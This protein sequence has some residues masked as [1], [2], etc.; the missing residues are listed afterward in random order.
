M[1]VYD[2]NVCVY[3]NIHTCIE[4]NAAEI[5]GEIIKVCRQLTKL[6]IHIHHSHLTPS[7]TPKP[8]TSPTSTQCLPAPCTSTYKTIYSPFLIYWVSP[9]NSADFSPSKIQGDRKRCF[10]PICIKNFERILLNKLQRNYF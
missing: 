7:T 3:R 2:A 5:L 9:T 10:F 8:P 1:D 4:A 6:N